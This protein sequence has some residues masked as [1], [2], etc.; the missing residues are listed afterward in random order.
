ML[1]LLDRVEQVGKMNE[2]LTQN[3]INKVLLNINKRKINIYLYPNLKILR[4]V[5]TKIDLIEKI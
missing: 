4:I 3:L 2:I 5:E 1:I